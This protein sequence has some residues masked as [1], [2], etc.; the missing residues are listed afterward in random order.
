VICEPAD[1][2]II[3]QIISEKI[4]RQNMKYTRLFIAISI[5]LLASL[6]C[7]TLTGDGTTAPSGNGGD[8]SG[9][10]SLPSDP[11]GAG[12]S[13]S[14]DGASSSS[15]ANLPQPSDASNVIDLGNDTITLTTKLSITDTISFY[16]DELGNLGYTQ[17]DIYTATTDTTFSIVF[18]GDPSGKKLVIQ[19]V[20]FNGS[21]TVTVRLEDF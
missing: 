19:G 17:A 2:A 16:Q 11:G 9:G 6:A 12:D 5:L 18:E 15:V 4:R 1:S 21:T 20:D 14:G 13:G 8:G 10:P 3:T 7:Q